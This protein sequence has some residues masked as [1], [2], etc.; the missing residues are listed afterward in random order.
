[1]WL[2]TRKNSVINRQL[3]IHQFGVLLL[4]F[5][6]R[7]I[8]FDFRDSHETMAFNNFLGQLGTFDRIVLLTA[9]GVRTDDGLLFF[10]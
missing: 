10:K 8:D 1:M 2:G 7:F 6:H 4:R 9:M 5:P 3:V